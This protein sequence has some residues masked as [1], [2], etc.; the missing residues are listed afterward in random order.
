MESQEDLHVVGITKNIQVIDK[1]DGSSF[2]P[3]TSAL[4][5]PMVV[6]KVPATVPTMMAKKIKTPKLL[7]NIQITK[8]NSPPRKVQ[9]PAKL[10]RPALSEK[11]PTKGRPRPCPKLSRAPIIEP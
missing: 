9:K 7:A 2:S 4:T 1:E 10:M 3:T 5:G 8:Q 6:Q 11:M